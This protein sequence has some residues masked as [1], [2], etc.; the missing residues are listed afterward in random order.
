MRNIHGLLAAI[1]R[2]QDEL[3]SWTPD[4]TLW[5]HMHTFNDDVLE[6]IHTVIG[7]PTPEEHQSLCL[8][9][10]KMTAVQRMYAE[11]YIQQPATCEGCGETVP[12]CHMHQHRIVCPLVT[13][14][15]H[16][17]GC[18]HR[19]SRQQMV[20]HDKTCAFRKTQCVWCCGMFLE[21]EVAR[22][23]ESCPHR[24]VTCAHCHKEFL[25]HQMERHNKICSHRPVECRWKGCNALVPHCELSSHQSSCEFRL[26]GCEWCKCLVPHKDLAAHREQCEMRPICCKLCRET[27]Q[28][29]TETGTTSALVYRDHML[30]Q[31]W[32]PQ[33][34]E[35]ITTHCV[36]CPGCDDVMVTSKQSCRQFKAMIQKFQMGHCDH[37]PH[38]MCDT[39]RQLTH[40]MNSHSARCSRYRHGH[41]CPFPLCP[42]FEVRCCWKSCGHLCKLKHRK[43]HEQ[44]CRHRPTSCPHCQHCQTTVNGHLLTTVQLKLHMRECRLHKLRMLKHV[45]TCTTLQCSCVEGPYRCTDVKMWD[46]HYKTCDKPPQMC[47][48]C[49]P[50][51][52][53]DVDPE[54]TAGSRAGRGTAGPRAGRG[55]ARSRAGRCAADS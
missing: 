41:V 51:I 5:T 6:H 14:R 45:Q 13:V 29:D 44:I 2:Q 22:H 31:H 34:E 53:M 1:D 43:D 15:C 25:N 40:L 7:T 38:T 50:L 32:L 19:C 36:T 47:E 55:T 54:G 39:C 27:L 12:L 18:G 17:E 24:K 49:A 11:K 33:M 9:L 52:S 35:V 10:D 23:S 46:A 28:G 42:N 37:S 20:V 21:S 48:K 30:L 8:D 4:D 16:W 26:V 3:C